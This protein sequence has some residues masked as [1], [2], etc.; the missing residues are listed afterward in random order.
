MRQQMM[1]ESIS[2]RPEP[3]VLSWVGNFK[4]LKLK[5]KSR[6][7]CLYVALWKF[8]CFHHIPKLYFFMNISCFNSKSHFMICCY[9]PLQSLL[10]YVNLHLFCIFHH[11]HHDLIPLKVKY[12]PIRPQT[13]INYHQGSAPIPLWWVHYNT[14]NKN[15]SHL[16]L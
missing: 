2:P 13:P 14:P 6:Q 10:N 3:G 11:P 8:S 12:S 15:G 5:D 7:I 1:S 4:K 16:E 9:T